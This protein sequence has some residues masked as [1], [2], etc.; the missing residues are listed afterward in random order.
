MIA[1]YPVSHPQC[2]VILD[3]W[4]RRNHERVV[5]KNVNPYVKTFI[6]V[7]KASCNLD[8]KHRFTISEQLYLEAH[9]LHFHF[10]RARYTYKLNGILLR[11]KRLEEQLD[12]HDVDAATA[13]KV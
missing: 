7:A 1:K 10:T 5:R 8:D 12:D 6:S 9:A 4:H 13:Y 2:Q 3:Q 11:L